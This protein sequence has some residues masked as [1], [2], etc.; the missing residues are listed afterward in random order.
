MSSIPQMLTSHFPGNPFPA[1]ADLSAASFHPRSIACVRTTFAAPARPPAA[2]RGK[3]S[4][5]RSK[6]D[7]NRKGE[8]ATQ[9]KA[10]GQTA[11]MAAARSFCA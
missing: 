7:K 8:L 3:L 4:V 11:A 9:P 1:S 10:R 2:A 5:Q 6:I